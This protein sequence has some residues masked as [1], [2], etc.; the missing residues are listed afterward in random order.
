MR[1][2]LI[3]GLLAI[4]GVFAGVLVATPARTQVIP[5][6]WFDCC[7]PMT[8]RSSSEYCCRSCCWFIPD[9][10]DDEDCNPPE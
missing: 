3:L 5:L 2:K 8:L 1:R 9:C 6:G 4:N 10:D 7:Q